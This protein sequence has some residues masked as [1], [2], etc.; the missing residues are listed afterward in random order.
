MEDKGMDGRMIQERRVRDRLGERKRGLV[1]MKL[2]S[3]KRG[4][5]SRGR[6][7]ED[8]GEQGRGRTG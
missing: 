4:M 1:M 7:R 5:K 6:E 3:W 8:G 2:G